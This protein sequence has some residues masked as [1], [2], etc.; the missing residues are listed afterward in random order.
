MA[1]IRQPGR[2]RS[3]RGNALIEFAF[4]LPLLLVIF[5]GIVDFGMLL[6]RYEVVTNAAREGARIAVLPGYTESLVRTRA[7]LYIQEG[8]NLTDGDLAA[9]VPDSAAG[10]ALEFD[11]LPVGGNTIDVAR[12]TVN[13]AHNF[14][15]LGP[16]LS[17]IG[18]AWGSSINL[19]AVS[20][21]R[22]EVPAGS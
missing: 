16:V 21:M 8:L 2:W 10:V 15:I 14:I 17:L 12:V 11:E 19:S 9:A 13:Y 20:T 7:R 1:P 3:E 22:V 18:Q 6:Q 5:A 4:V